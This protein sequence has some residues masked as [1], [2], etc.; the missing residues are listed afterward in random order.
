ML[1]VQR[2]ASQQ[3]F[4]QKNHQMKT[5]IG[6]VSNLCRISVSASLSLFLFLSVCLSVSL[7]LSPFPPPPPFCLIWELRKMRNVDPKAVYSEPDGASDQH[8]TKKTHY[9]DI[10]F[11]QGQICSKGTEAL[12]FSE[13]PLRALSGHIQSSFLPSS[14]PDESELGL[15]KTPN[16]SPQISQFSPC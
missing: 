8:Q 12:V 16:Q 5:S 15:E 4:Q 1:C 11:S 2:T 6:R 9:L 14:A 7:S 13:T 3:S 10:R